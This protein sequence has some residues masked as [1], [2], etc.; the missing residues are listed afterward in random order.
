MIYDPATGKT[1]EQ[2]AF[3]NTR[4]GVSTGSGRSKAFMG[5]RK[6]AKGMYD[7]PRASYGR[8]QVGDTAS[9]A[10]NKGI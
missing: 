5:K 9:D 2:R 7:G 6:V 4:N 8:Y 1:R 3:G 10:I